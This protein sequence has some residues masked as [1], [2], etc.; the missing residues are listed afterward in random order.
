MPARGRPGE[1][2]LLA[3]PASSVLLTVALGFPLAGFSLAGATETPPTE[4]VFSDFAVEQPLTAQPGDAVAGREVF[5]DR[6]LG[7]CLA[8]HVNS[9]LEGEGFHGTVG[10]PLDGVASRWKP[11]QL[12]AIVINAKQVFGPDTMMPAFYSLDV[13]VNV[14][15]KFQGKT[16]LTAQQVEDLVAYLQ[17]LTDR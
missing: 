11:A 3:K 14:A 17:T 8:C 7:N 5:A 2:A 1:E 9:D 15:E 16:I 4:V 6:G 13:G 12:R 10:P